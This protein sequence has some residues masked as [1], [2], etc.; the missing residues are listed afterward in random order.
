MGGLFQTDGKLMGFLTVVSDICIISILWLL[1]CLPLLTMG[2]A[3]TAAYYTMVKTVRRQRGSLYAEFVKSLKLNFKDA[4]IIHMGYLL[5]C[6]L[7]IVNVYTMYRSLDTAAAGWEFNVLFLCGTLLLLTV[8]AM[9]Y[10]Y[11][12]LSRFTMKRMQLVRFSVFAMFRHFFSTILLVG[13]FVV[14]LLVIVA[15]PIGVL[16]MPGV[17]LYGYTFVMEIIL[18]KYMLK[19]MLEQ[20]DENE[21]GE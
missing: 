21:K 2:A 3:T 5:I 15:F 14:T 18:R 4:L 13:L 8:T 20:W 9:I 7:L 1:C 11:P 6:G 10:T 19:D 17:C 12:A 16:F